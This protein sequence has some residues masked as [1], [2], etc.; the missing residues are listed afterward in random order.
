M[1]KRITAAFSHA[2]F[3]RKKKRQ[4]QTDE[5]THHNLKSSTD[6]ETIITNPY[7]KTHVVL[8]YTSSKV[9][10]QTHIHC[11]TVISIL[12]NFNILF[13]KRDLFMSHRFC[14]ELSEIFGKKV[15]LPQLFI[16]GK[17]VGGFNKIME[18]NECGKLREMVKE[19]VIERPAEMCRGCGDMRY[20]VCFNCRGSKR[21]CGGEGEAV[22]MCILCNENGLLPCA[23]CLLGAALPTND[24][25]AI[26]RAWISSVVNGI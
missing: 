8:Y 13:Q 14:K 25:S 24:V 1:L 21:F 22:E 7:D 26:Y 4:D 10:R 17:Y 19:C 6:E 11:S 9:I 15:S 12:T 23:V 16:R 3:K 20:I 2:P 5:E 18:L